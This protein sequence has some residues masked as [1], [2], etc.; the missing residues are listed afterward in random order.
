MTGPTPEGVPSEAIVAR[1]ALLAALKACKELQTGA[2][3][4]VQPTC[5]AKRRA[6]ACSSRGHWHSCSTMS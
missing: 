2:A 4:V 6:I 1:C 3:S 5:G